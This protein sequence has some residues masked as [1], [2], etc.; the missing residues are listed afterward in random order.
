MIA[1]LIEY[2]FSNPLFIILDQASEHSTN[3]LVYSSRLDQERCKK[4]TRK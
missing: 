4:N 3:Q 1:I 2:I